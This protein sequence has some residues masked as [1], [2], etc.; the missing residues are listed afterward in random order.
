MTRDL[1]DEI[2]KTIEGLT[3]IYQRVANTSAEPTC[4]VYLLGSSGN[5]WGGLRADV[6]LSSKWPVLMRR[7]LEDRMTRGDLQT[8]DGIIVRI[9]SATDVV[10]V[11]GG[12]VCVVRRI[13]PP[14]TQFIVIDTGAI[15]DRLPEWCGRRRVIRLLQRWNASVRKIG[16]RAWGIQAL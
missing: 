1:V 11:V 8:D 12:P 15:V 10:A 7:A 13:S 5:T 2:I 6:F 3:P 9:G 16:A 4:S 14:S